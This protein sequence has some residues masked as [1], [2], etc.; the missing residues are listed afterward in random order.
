M[1]QET[2]LN[3]S[4]YFDDFDRN[5]NY[6][7]VL[8][9]PGLPV[10]AR[11]LTSLQSILQDQ[12]EQI[13]THLFKEGSM[14]IPGQ[15]NYNNELLSVEVEEEYLGI[16]IY[17]ILNDLI[18]VN[19]RGANSNVT[20]R[21]L[22]YAEGDASERDYVTLFV[23]YTG[24]GVEGKSVFDDDEV[25]LLEDDFIGA[26][27]NLQAGQGISK[28][29][30][31]SSTSIGSAVFLS[32]GVYFLRGTFVNVPGQTLILDAHGSAPS[33]RV[34][35][36]IYEEFISSG[37]DPSLT[38]NAKGFNNYAAPGADRL[39]I[40]AVLAKRDLDSRKNENFVELMIIR[41]G[42]VQHIED[43]IKYNELAEELARRTYDQAGNFYVKPFSIHPRESLND[44]KGNNGVFTKDQ[45]TYNSNVPSDDL[46]T[47]KISPGKAFIRGFEVESKTVHYLDFEK[48]RSTKILK[49]QGVNYFTG[50]T[51][52]LNRVVGA[53]RLGFSTTSTISL[54]DT[55]IGDSATIVAGKEIGVARVYD[56]ALESGSYS[57][58]APNLNEWDISLY[59]IQPYTEMVLNQSI[60]LST[61]TY[62]Q[63]KSSGATGHLRFDTTTGIVTA[64]NTKGTFLKGEKLTFNGIDNGRVSTAVTSFGIADVK[65]LYSAVGTGQTFNANV[66]QSRKI[67]YPSVT[68]SPKS[69]G[70]FFCPPR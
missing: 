5:K 32:D 2:N 68:I 55:R 66:K 51:L 58:V 27:I 43:K 37:Q 31:T 49:D 4:P 22:Y 33:Y 56:Y 38:D 45:L 1:P 6:Y 44:N 69:A 29:A 16:N 24:T 40:T 65:S 3:V 54:R 11:E 52:T 70:A 8:F 7:K 39:K 42:N 61:P 14:V 57:S 15:I 21:I 13:G 18:Q 67:N 30:A 9:K 46:G 12:V 10:Q 26:E 48:T 50:P 62:I 35:L 17:S 41:N 23:N 64:Y 25:L 20:A 19:V 63:G 28:T 53:P 36:E 47:Y 60:T 59:D 34:G